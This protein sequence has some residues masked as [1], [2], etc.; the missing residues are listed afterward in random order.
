MKACFK[1]K[2]AV[3][4]FV[5]LAI[6]A[7][8]VFGCA[9]AQSGGVKL[10]EKGELMHYTEYNRN[11]WL[12]PV[13]NTREVYNETVLFVGENDEAGLLYKPEK[14]LSVRS[15][16]LDKE[17]REGKDYEI[18]QGGKIRRLTGSEIPYFEVDEYYRTEPDSVPV[19]IFGKSSNP[20][21]EG[22][23]YIK[24]GEGDTFTSRQIAVTYAHSS[25]WEG[26]TPRFAANRQ[27][28]F[29]DKRRRKESV[30]AVFYGDSITVGCNASGTGHG[31][32][33]APYTPSYPQMVTDYLGDKFG[34]EINYVNTAEGG[35]NTEWGADNVQ[36]NV[37]EYSPD[38]AVIAFGMNDAKLPLKTYKRLVCDMADAIRAAKPDCAVI[39]VAT[40]VP[41]NE[42]DWYYGNQKEYVKALKEIETDKNYGF[43]SVADMT[44]MHLDI[45]EK[46]RFRD[47]TGNNINHPNDFLVRV[48]AQVL[49]HTILGAEFTVA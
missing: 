25:P 15:Y 39:L 13:W 35:K 42:T 43:V 30:T 34:C 38:L 21:T 7:I 24:Y 17:Y 16:G 33:I 3:L 31:G 40:S 2:S 12:K 49:L 48:Y 26:A 1:I 11:A 29:T 32:N 46:K 5:A 9:P 23:R 45:L 14:V 28:S 47:I 36:K 41:N 44:S 22:Q 6:C 20:A 37:I 10:A 8:S 27:K 4:A 19:A 18:T